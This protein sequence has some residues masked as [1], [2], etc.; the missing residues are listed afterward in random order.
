MESLRVFVSEICQPR[1]FHTA[2]SMDVDVE[3]VSVT[4][5]VS[6]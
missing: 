4:L 3:C 5:S 1:V 6:E 2:D